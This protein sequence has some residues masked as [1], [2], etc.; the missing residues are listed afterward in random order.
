MS[1]E[2]GVPIPGTGSP[3]AE[4]DGDADPG[5]DRSLRHVP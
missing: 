3:A 1:I 2:N 4:D 5:V